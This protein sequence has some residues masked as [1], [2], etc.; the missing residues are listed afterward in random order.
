MRLRQLAAVLLP[1]W[2]I[3]CAAGVDVQPMLDD[4]DR[5]DRDFRSR[6]TSPEAVPALSAGR[7]KRG[8]AG[9][10]ADAGKK[11]EAA[12]VA[13]KALAD[14]QLALEMEKRNESARRADACR[15]EVAQARVS[16]EQALFTLEKTEDFAGK[17]APVTRNAP[18]SPPEFSALPATT[19]DGD[20]AMS[21]AELSDQ[22]KRWRQAADERQVPV[23]ELENQYRRNI[24]VMQGEK[25]EPAT[26]EHHAYLAGRTVQSLECRVRAAVH[27]NFCARAAAQLGDFGDA[28]ADALAATLELERGLKDDIRRDLDQ[29]RAEART[30]QEELFGALSQLEGKFASIHQEARGTI[31]SLADI[32]FDFDKATLRRNVEFNLVKI[33]TILN[34]FSEM[35]I[36]I[37]GHT[38]SIG[39]DEYNL[40]LSRRRAQAVFEFLKS[41][42]V[43]ESRMTF[44]G[45]GESRPVADNE[46][47]EGR[48]RNRRV[49]LVIQDAG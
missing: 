25:V 8:E 1:V 49:D 9:A 47:D 29:L 48:Q 43:A 30:R 40:D 27:E 35:G 41:Q 23:A 10:L 32:L 38:D 22:W 4:F 12:P 34:Q 45:Y 5:Y 11:G 6:K 19:L 18:P 13:E 2:L 44:E 46:T 36:L 14:A 20:A 3:G 26:A 28:R 16:W 7:E 21:A 33:A 24:A 42:D 39:T 17:K 15:L 31:V 37:E